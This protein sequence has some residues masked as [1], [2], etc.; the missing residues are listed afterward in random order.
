MQKE[1]EKNSIEKLSKEL[2]EAAKVDADTAG[3][4]LNTLGIEDLIRHINA[5]NSVVDSDRGLEELSLDTI[6]VGLRGHA[7]NY[8][9]V[10]A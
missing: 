4:V 5:I 7:V 1:I 2:A 9:D 10:V 6:R 8:M 3:R